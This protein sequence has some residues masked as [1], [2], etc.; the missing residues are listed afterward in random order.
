M[1]LI[2]RYNTPILTRP[3]LHFTSPH[4]TSPT[5]NILHGTPL[6]NPLHC[7]SLH[8]NSLHFLDSLQPTQSC[9]CLRS[10]LLCD[11]TQRMVAVPFRRFGTTYRVPSS[12]IKKL[13]GFLQP[14]RRDRRVFRHLRQTINHHTL[15][16]IT[17]ER[18]SH[19][20]SGGCPKWS[21]ICVLF[22][23]SC[24]LISRMG[25][26]HCS[27]LKNLTLKWFNY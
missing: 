18:W 17:Q 4:F 14:W 10:T 21:I 7:T 19:L 22:C 20:I 13:L 8:F 26:L 9:L 16:N 27:N 2:Q 1:L 15:Y 12:M 11:I 24:E 23:V 25:F 3:S 5:I 6:F